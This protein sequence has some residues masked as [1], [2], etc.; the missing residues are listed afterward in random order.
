VPHLRLPYLPHSRPASIPRLHQIRGR[1]I[2]A[3]ALTQIP[4]FHQSYHLPILR[5]S[6]SCGRDSY[7]SPAQDLPDRWEEAGQAS[8]MKGASVLVGL[9]LT[10]FG[11]TDFA[12][13]IFDIAHDSAHGR[14]A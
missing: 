3:P 5:C 14:E 6:G 11:L 10:E 12:P 13:T 2:F 1:A 4:L 7:A 8:T 9:G